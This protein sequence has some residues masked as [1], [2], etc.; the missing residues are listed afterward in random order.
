MPLLNLTALPPKAMP[1]GT[2]DGRLR[3]IVGQLLLT[4]FAGRK[5]TDP[6]VLQIA[7]AA[8]DGK[9]SG[10]IVRGSNIEDQRQLRQLLTGIA[11]SSGDVPTVIAIEQAGGPDAA[12]TEEKGFAYYASANA[13]S[14]GNSPY[15]AQLLYRNMAADLAA[16]GI[17]LNI[18]PSEDVC[19][20][21]GVDLSASCFG[22]A[23]SRIAAFARA[24]NFGHHDSGVLTALRHTPFRKGLQSSWL[25]EPVSTAILHGIVK[26]ETSDALVVRV[27]VLEPLQLTEASFTHARGKKRGGHRSSGF[28]G[29]LIF[30]LDTGTSGAPLRY[31]EAI[32]RAFQ[33]GA[34]MVLVTDPSSLPSDIFTLSF[35]AVQGG[36]KS[37]RLQMARI[38]DAYLRVQRLKERLRVVH[39][40]AKIAALAAKTFKQ[41]AVVLDRR[42]DQQQRP[43]PGS[44]PASLCSPS[45]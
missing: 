39:S 11:K 8:R 23:P 6:G 4:G 16:L 12:L 10:I 18:G 14:N 15:E 20:E 42:S 37:G 29:V 30:E 24:F 13:V 31:D 36:L 3:K 27:K 32:L 1:Q 45:P 33:A 17:T 25:D 7:G 5:P 43:D 21:Q 34:D 19:R 22:T 40:P 26:G 41:C 38:E 35:D 44:I 2:P 28:H 9:L